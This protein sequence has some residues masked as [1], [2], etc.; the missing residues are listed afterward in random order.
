LQNATAWD[1]DGKEYIDMLSMFSVVNMGHA[2]PRLVKAATEAI[3]RC[4]VVNL[5]FLN[6]SYGRLAKKLHEVRLVLPRNQFTP[7]NPG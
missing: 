5:P 6:P 2:H 1:V 3:Q 7:P 4:G